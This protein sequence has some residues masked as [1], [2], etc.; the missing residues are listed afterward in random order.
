MSGL[1]NIFKKTINKYDLK[2]D[3]EEIRD[4]AAALGEKCRKIYKEYEPAIKKQSKIA[5]KQIT[6]AYHEFEPIIEK[7]IKKI[8]TSPKKTAA[9]K[10]TKSKKMAKKRK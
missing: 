9:K 8:I 7:E 10:K 1:P 4:K 6:K 2:I 3:K 5:A